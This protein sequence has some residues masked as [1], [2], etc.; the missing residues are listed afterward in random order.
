[1]VVVSF[2]NRTNGGMLEKGLGTGGWKMGTHLYFRHITDPVV[3]ATLKQ[4]NLGD[5]HL[6][7]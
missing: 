4:M 2:G 1:V 6:V 7:V 5:D 3:H